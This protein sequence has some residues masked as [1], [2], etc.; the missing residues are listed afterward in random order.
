MCGR[1]TLSTPGDEL[2][3]I[4]GLDEVPEFPPRFNI[5]PTQPIAVIRE[6]RRLELL[7]W[8]LVLPGAHRHG[9]QG[10]NVR[11]ETVA[12][13]PAYRESFRKRRCL[14]I[15]S[16]FFEWQRRD[17]VKQPFFI[18]REDSKPFALA[19]I[20]DSSIT[21]HG[22]VIES[23]AVITG[24]SKGAMTELHNRMP[25][26][27]PATGY[28]RWLDPSGRELADL[29]VPSATGLVTYPV[30]T[31]V[32]SPANDDPRCIEPV[33]EGAEL[34]GTLSLF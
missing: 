2:R 4:F 9:A 16:G 28:A 17:K 12:R 18:R 11:V 3:D 1:A 20:W 8:G 31:L 32:N 23:C 6:P 27:V 10:I 15:V 21:S 26:I 7:R 19:G 14:V 24:D 34:K 33:A 29:L 22:E 13:A 5:A 30:S 25:L